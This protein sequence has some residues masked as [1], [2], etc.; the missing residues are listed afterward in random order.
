MQSLMLIPN[1]KLKLKKKQNF[2]IEGEGEGV[3]KKEE[4]AFFQS[5]ASRRDFVENF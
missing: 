3:V 4:Y 1:I 5:F 2:D